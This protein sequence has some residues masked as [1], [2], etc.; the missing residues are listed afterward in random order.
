MKVTPGVSGKVKAGSA[1]T[2]YGTRSPAP[3]DRL[4]LLAEP[5]MVARKYGASL[6]I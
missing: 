5:P 3:F 2:E 4:K 6:D 1:A